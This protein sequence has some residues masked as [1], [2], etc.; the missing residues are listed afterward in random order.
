MVF[1]MYMTWQVVSS[2]CPR[3]IRFGQSLSELEKLSSVDLACREIPIELGRLPAL[4]HLKLRGLR[5]SNRGSH[6]P[7][8]V[9]LRLTSLAKSAYTILKLLT[10]NLEAKLSN[11]SLEKASSAME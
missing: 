2:S 10:L 5:P 11:A 6:D 8:E 7:E 4:K 1:K 3:R 9:I